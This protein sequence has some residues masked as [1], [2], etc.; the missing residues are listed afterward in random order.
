MAEDQSN[1]ITIRTTGLSAT[2]NPL[3][4][5]LSVL[6]DAAERDLLWNGDPAIWAGRAPLLFPIV[7]MLAGGHYRIGDQSYALPRHGFARNRRFTVA[8]AGPTSVTF[9]LSADAETLAVYPF[10]F[11]LE[12]NFSIRG[13][14]LAVTSWIRNRG[15][16]DMP[17]SLGYHPAFAWPLPYG[18]AR[19]AHFI[20]F[21]T[22]EP[23]PIRRLDGN[24]LLAPEHLLTPVQ[25]RR[26]NL[27]DELFSADALIFDQ[28]SSRTVTY[29]SEV[30][31]RI[32]VSFP[33]V[34]F[35]GVWSK[36]AAPF[37]CI[38]PWQG[39]TDP[40]GFNGELKDKPGSVLVP[41]GRATAVGMTITLLP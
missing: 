22:D 33:G 24:G 37:I 15:S 35:L 25:N 1:W 28:L 29:G 17:A 6:R 36:P 40:Q 21:E 7:G 34:P 10:P 18:E 2:I 20:E 30:G 39:V 23:A 4:A 8:E 5:Q 27:K 32:A 16:V 31:P 41:P 38:E 11:E 19:A 12:V 13:A 14:S 9:V 3:G 26:L